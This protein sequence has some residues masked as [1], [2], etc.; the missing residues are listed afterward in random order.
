[1]YKINFT[2]CFNKNKQFNTYKSPFVDF[3]NFCLSFLLLDSPIA[4]HLSFDSCD[5]NC[6][7]QGNK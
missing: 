3:F 1:M 6:S 2:S 5:F 7:S 4:G